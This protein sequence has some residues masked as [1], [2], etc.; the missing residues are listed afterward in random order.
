[1]ALLVAS[2]TFGVGLAI[3]PVAPSPASADRGDI[4]TYT[5]A[6]GEID[7]PTDIAVAPDGTVWFTSRANDLIGRLVPETGDITTFGESANPGTIDGPSHLTIGA[8]GNVWFSNANNDFI[9]RLDVGTGVV[10]VYE[11]PDLSGPGDLVLGPDGNVWF[12]ADR[13]GRITP[14]GV[15]STYTAAA[16]DIVNGPDGR[17]WFLTPG[18]YVG[19][20]TTSGVGTF[21]PQPVTGARDLAFDG[22]GN[23]W[24]AW[25]FFDDDGPHENLFMQIYDPQ[26]GSRSTG[27]GVTN[28]LDGVL[29]G[30]PDLSVW[31]LHSGSTSDVSAPAL[32]RVEGASFTRT[33]VVPPGVVRPSAVALTE[34]L[35]GDLWYASASND[36][37]GHVDASGPDVAVR[38]SAAERS[39][40]V[41][42]DIHYEVTITNTGTTALTGIEVSDANAPACSGPVS[43]LAPGEAVT[44]ECAFT[45]TA[46]GLRTNTATVATAQTAAVTSN[47][48]QTQVQRVPTHPSFTA[49]MSSPDV[50]V[51]V[52]EEIRYRLTITNTG[53]VTLTGVT[54][55]DPQVPDCEGPVDDLAVGAQLIVECSFPTTAANEG[56]FVNSAS[57]DTAQTSPSQSAGPPVVVQ[58]GRVRSAS[59]VQRP[60]QTT[61]PAGTPITWEVVVGNTGDIPLAQVGEIDGPDSVQVSELGTLAVGEEVVIAREYA[62]SAVDLGTFTNTA[63]VIADRLAPLSSEPFEV[64]VTIPPAGFTDVAP[65]A[66]YAGAVD[67]AALFEVVPGVTETTFRPSKVVTRARLV[68]ALFRMMDQPPVSPRHTFDDV[69]TLLWMSRGCCQAAWAVTGGARASR[70]MG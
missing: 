7:E 21:S 59:I 39:V 69:P 55:T 41:G 52:G 33:A 67:W 57:V 4:T 11:A 51:L 50:G 18:G 40:F 23:L 61:V 44:V 53:D 49:S 56:S 35:H 31:F 54:V 37:I 12:A 1:M 6:D 65:A 27:Y 70:M 64:E 28:A 36:L 43:D 9:G 3:V 5:D 63:T 25:G 66:F 10:N 19:A 47:A 29:A 13:I 60:G 48:V 34:G 16:T 58:V 30:G 38:L 2:A 26:T 45:T 42:E 32:G 20:V 17:L 15:I 22:G 14:N 62:T 46:A 8:D 68:D 24:V